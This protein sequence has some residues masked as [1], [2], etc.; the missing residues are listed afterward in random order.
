M[1][2]TDPDR[3]RDSSERWL[4]AR[5]NARHL[6]GLRLASLQAMVLASLPLWPAAHGLKVPA[7]VTWFGLLF[8][9]TS[10]A[11]AAGYAWLEHRWSRRAEEAPSPHPFVHEARY[12]LRA[13]L[14]C[15]LSAASLLPWASCAFGRALPGW[16]LG[17]LTASAV[18]LAAALVA[19]EAIRATLRPSLK[20]ERWVD[21]MP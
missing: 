13:R 6:R 19:T 4:A 10:L 15:G 2:V 7:L 1:T 17:P 16:L 8:A 11:L 12:E 20:A 14:W 21:H 18:L 3:R 9:S 5:L